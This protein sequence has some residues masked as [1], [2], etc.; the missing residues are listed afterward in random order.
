MADASTWQIV[1]GAVSGVGFVGG[2]AVQWGLL[3]SLLK[4]AGATAKEARASTEG[5]ASF[6]AE[7]NAR[8]QGLADKL[9]VALERV[10]DLEDERTTLHERV[11]VLQQQASGAVSQDL[12]D[13][14]HG[15]ERR[16]HRSP[17]VEPEPA[18]VRR[19]RRTT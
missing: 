11:R 9:A 19:P 6:K 7:V 2:I 8:L 1:V 4:G 16:P 3:A 13:M 5:L 18:D 10:D 14:Q 12:C 15:R 17:A